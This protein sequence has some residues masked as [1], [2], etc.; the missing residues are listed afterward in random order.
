MEDFT[1]M[2]SIALGE[3]SEEAFD[4]LFVTYYPKVLNFVC[5]F[6]NDRAEAENI[7]QELFLYLWTNRSRMP[8][9]L[10][11]DNYLFVAARN[12]AIR[13][14][15]QSLR[16]TSD[17]GM[18][19][20]RT[21]DTDPEVKM[22]YDELRQMIMREVERMPEQRRRIFLMSRADGLSNADIADRLGISKRTV[23]THIH[24]A[25]VELREL[26]PVIALL[27]LLNH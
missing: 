16:F 13:Y 6:C 26:L 27:T 1:N 12:A 18:A 2:A 17:D 5:K 23:E 22:C 10:N 9:I 21:D 24:L 4:A 7:V 25:L 8:A 20:S 3:G 19:S 14:M 15:K 11:L